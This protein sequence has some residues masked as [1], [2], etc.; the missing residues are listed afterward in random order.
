M[1]I[2]GGPSFPTVLALNGQA[3][4]NGSSAS[5]GKLDCSGYD[6]LH[7]EV[8]SNQAVTLTVRGTAAEEPATTMP[9]IGDRLGGGVVTYTGLSVAA[10]TNGF[11][12]Q[13][14]CKGLR[15]V[16]AY[17]INSSGAT[18]TVTA[19]VSLH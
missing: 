5:C 18:A 11:G 13:L 8:I 12:Y 3:I 2:T 7:V 14:W 17:V 10:G 16:E 15:W 9:E 19:R 6:V 1:S 4:N